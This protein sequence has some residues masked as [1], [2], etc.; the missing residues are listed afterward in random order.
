[1]KKLLTIVLGL[2]MSIAL[3]GCSSQDNQSQKDINYKEIN[4]LKNLPA[5]I[6]EEIPD[7]KNKR[8]YYVFKPGKYNLENSLVLI[9]SGEKRTSGYDITPIGIN[10][11]NKNIVITVKETEPDKDSAVNQVLTYPITLVEI[12]GN[13]SKNITVLNTDNDNFKFIQN[14]KGKNYIT[15]EGT[16]VGRIDNNF[17]EIKIDGKP[18]SFKLPAYGKLKTKLQSNQ[19]IKFSYYKNAKGQLV[20]NNIK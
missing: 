14:N 20:I 10:R 12:K 18:Q 4:S 17:V 3:V 11:Q 1:M 5:N 16:Y 6:T 7:I 15:A 13:I 9:S 19:Y 2:I 8:G